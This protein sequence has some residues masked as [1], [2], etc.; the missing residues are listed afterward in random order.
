VHEQFMTETA[1]FADIV[2]PATM[3]LEHDDIYTASGHTIFQVA[4]AVIEPPG[5]CRENHFV[6]SRTR[7]APGRHASRLRHDAWEIMDETLKVSGMWD[8]E[9]NWRTAARTSAGLRD[10]A[11]PRRLRH[12]GRQV[13]L[14]ARLEAA[15]G[16]LARK[17]RCC[18]TIST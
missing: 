9:T 6:I 11:F 14:Q 3:F 16:P 5:E 2:L 13:P 1:A 7:K 8:A 17:C 15:Y 18:P 12:A 10:G 4:K